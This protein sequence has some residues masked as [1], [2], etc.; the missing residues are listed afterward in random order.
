[1]L[2]VPSRRGNRNHASR[3]GGLGDHAAQRNIP[4]LWLR[5]DFRREDVHGNKPAFV[6]RAELSQR[7]GPPA[8]LNLYCLHPVASCGEEDAAD[9]RDTPSTK[10]SSKYD[11]C[12]AP[13][14]RRKSGRR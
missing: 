1:V 9:L 14:R 6:Q 3:P 5:S 11:A 2:A 7:L 12:A 4:K 13:S 8:G 10:L